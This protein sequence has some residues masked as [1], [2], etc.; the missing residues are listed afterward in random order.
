MPPLCGWEVHRPYGA[1]RAMFYRR[2]PN[3]QRKLGGGKWN[4]DLTLSFLRNPQSPSLLGRASAGFF[5]SPLKNS[6]Y[7]SLI[8]T[9][10][11]LQGGEQ[12]APAPVA[13]APPSPPADL[14]RAITAI[15][16]HDIEQRVKHLNHFFSVIA[17]LQGS[18]NHERGGPVA[19]DLARFYQYATA[20]AFN[21]SV[22]NSK[23]ISSKLSELF[24]TLGDAW[25]EG[26]R[27][28][29]A[30]S[31]NFPADDRT[32]RITLSDTET[33]ELMVSNWTV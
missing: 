21:A 17:E 12:K 33:M 7:T 4:P 28:L 31:T 16:A 27:V 9:L 19:K 30:Q 23:E 6:D 29:A 20:Q 10:T 5:C 2:A 22:E 14:Q 8:E 1:V 32:A 3:F 26:E 18:L 24:S 15:E 13:T 25:R 11:R